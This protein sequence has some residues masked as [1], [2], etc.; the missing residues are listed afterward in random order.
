MYIKIIT[1]ICAS[2][3]YIFVGVIAIIAK[4]VEQIIYTSRQ[5]FEL[6]YTTFLL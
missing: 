1:A 6:W 2:P 5:V 4:T 3:I